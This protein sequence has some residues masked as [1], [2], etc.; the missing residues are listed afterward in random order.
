MLFALGVTNAVCPVCDWCCLPCVWL[1]L[2][3]LGKADVCPCVSWCLPCVWLLCVTDGGECGGQFSSWAGGLSLCQGGQ[4]QCV[5]RGRDLHAQWPQHQNCKYFLLWPLGA[6][7][8]SGCGK[9]QHAVN[10]VELCW[11]LSQLQHTWQTH[12]HWPWRLRYCH[13]DWS[14]GGGEHYCHEDWG[15]GDRGT[16][17]PWRL[18]L[19]GLGTLLPWRLGLWGFGNFIAMK[20]GV[21]GV[22][23]FIAMK[24]GVVGLGTLLP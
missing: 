23:N 7:Q 24:T 11:L 1:M 14:C 15:C 20:T 9:K 17:L 16:L 4:W 22:G 13:E 3:A 18:G 19:W 12:Q 5:H 2:F 8:T 21:V 6:G 10:A